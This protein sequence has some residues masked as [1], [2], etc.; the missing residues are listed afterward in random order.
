[1][2]PRELITTETE[3]ELVVRSEEDRVID[4]R[5]LRWADIAHTSAGPE[6][7]ARGAFR[8]TDPASVTLEA[9]GPHGAEPGVRLAGRGIACSE[10]DDGPHLSVRVSRTGAGDELLELVRDGVY[11]NVSLVAEPVSARV[12]ADGVLE[13]TRVNLVR[14]GVV[15]RGAY[16]GANVLAVRSADMAIETPAAEPT[17]PTPDTATVIARGADPEGALE[18]L[19]SEMVNRMTALEA[20][21]SSSAPSPLAAYASLGHYIIAAQSDP[22]AAVLLARVLADQTTVNN[23]GVMPPAFVR[24]VKGNLTAIREAIAAFGGG[25]SLGDS[26]MALEWPY[27]DGDLKTLVGKQAA[28]KTE[29]TSV[30]VDL[31]RG[32]APIVTFAGGSDISYQLI[33]RSSP[34]YVEAYGRIMLAGWALTTEAEF[35]GDLL[36]GATGSIVIDWLTATADAIR[37]AFFEASQA[38]KAATGSPASA[39]LASSDVFAHLGGI[40]GLWPA[41]YGT[42]NIAGTATASTL[43]INVSG[44]AVIEAPFFPVNTMLFGNGSAAAWHE[45]GPFIAT[46]EDVAKLGQN[47]AVWSMGATGIY[48]PAGLVASAAAAGT[49]RSSST[50]SK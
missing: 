9:I 48:L 2:S 50:A 39:A 30:R 19:R 23:P 33:R 11:R 45:D 47:R 20:R 14:L 4:A 46:A 26:G 6:R 7:F 32:T 16:Q 17:T 22:D 27:Y 5:L 1:L 13:R 37:A 40:P 3:A 21:G 43:A 34:S 44:L 38:V 25:Q 15:E 41:P 36:A 29:I 49:R 12:A 18:A 24:D 35:E 42:Q 8:G 28:E 31:K 10:E